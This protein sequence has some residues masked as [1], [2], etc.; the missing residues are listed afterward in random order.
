MVATSAVV[1]RSLRKRVTPLL[2]EA[3]FQKVDARNGWRWREKVVLVFNIRAVGSYFADV[4]GWPP[5]SVGVW[6]GGF[7]TFGVASSSI[8]VDKEGRRLPAEYQCHMR[9]H[10]ECGL[11]QANRVCA[12]PNPAERA[13]RDIWWLD[14]DGANSEE[15]ASDI[16]VSL[17]EHG[18]PW[19]WHISDLETALASVEGERDCFAKFERAAFLARELGDEKRW[20]KYKALAEAEAQRIGRSANESARHVAS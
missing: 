9:S 1:N 6:L 13:R 10:L 17:L 14:P 16:A 11:D 4:T 15:V 19:Y 2:R 5:G 20:Q 7:Y 12:L 3:G 8:K 18:V